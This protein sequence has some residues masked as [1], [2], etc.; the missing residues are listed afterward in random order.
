[1]NIRQILH[2]AR[3][4]EW[5]TTARMSGFRFNPTNWGG[6]TLVNVSRD[7]ED[8]WTVTADGL[9]IAALVQVVKGKETCLGQHYIP[10]QIGVVCPCCP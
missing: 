9:S 7:G 3:N 5:T 6:T 8:V 2:M 10:F 1:M 4:S